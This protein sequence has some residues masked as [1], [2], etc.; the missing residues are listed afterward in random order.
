MIKTYEGVAPVVAA[1]AYVDEMA[2]VIGK[3]TIG[4]E[5]SIWPMAVLRGDCNTIAIGDR[6]S[7]QDGSVIHVNH[8]APFNPGGDRVVVGNDVTVGHKVMLHGCAIMDRCLIGMASTIMDKVVIESNVMV[9][10][11]SLVSPGKTLESGHLYVG[12]PAKR[13]REL[14][15]EELGFLDHAAEYYAQL[16][17]RYKQEALV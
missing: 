16:G 17:A 5:S 2:A 1:S 7:I 9:G 13:V 4:E 14:T 8:D 10:A 12:A 6:T 11:G 15:D 3:V